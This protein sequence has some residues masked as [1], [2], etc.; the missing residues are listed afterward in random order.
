MPVALGLWEVS[1]NLTSEL[2][3][4]LLFSVAFSFH[5]GYQIPSRK[6]P[7]PGLEAWLR[8]SALTL[9]AQDLGLIP[10]YIGTCLL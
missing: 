7:P 3:N 5:R 10:R 8:G 1:A 4:L 9:R 6:I 2:Y